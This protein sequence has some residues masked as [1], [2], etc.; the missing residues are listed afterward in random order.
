MHAAI[1]YILTTG[2]GMWQSVRGWDSPHAWG[3]QGSS[4]NPSGGAWRVRCLMLKCVAA[5]AALRT[6]GPENGHGRGAAAGWSAAGAGPNM[7]AIL[8]GQMCLV[9]WRV[10]QR[11]QSQACSASRSAPCVCNTVAASTV[12]GWWEVGL[13]WRRTG[14]VCVFWGGVP[15]FVAVGPLRVSVLCVSDRLP[16]HDGRSVTTVPR[17]LL[18]R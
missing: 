7:A 8:G 1:A 18:E 4:L 2:S 15:V 10:Q 16:H 3:F 9:W 11:G 13:R 6:A 17:E 5:Q 14:V 12:G